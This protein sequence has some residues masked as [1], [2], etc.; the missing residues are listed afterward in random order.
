MPPYDPGRPCE[1]KV[2][3]KRTEPADRLR[4]RPG[5]EL[6]DAARSG[7][8]GRRLVGGLAA[9]LLLDA[10]EAADDPELVD[11]HEERFRER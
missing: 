1:I 7:V 8:A 5:V 9:V 4:V 11:E 2:E 10:A 3:F 6:L